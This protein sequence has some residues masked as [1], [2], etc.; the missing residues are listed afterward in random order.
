MTSMSM[1]VL[2]SGLPVSWARLSVA[3]TNGWVFMPTSASI[4][5]IL[6]ALWGISMLPMQLSVS[7]QSLACMPPNCRPKSVFMKDWKKTG[8]RG[9]QSRWC[10]WIWRMRLD[11][12]LKLAWQLGVLRIGHPQ[13]G[14]WDV[15]QCFLQGKVYW[16][17]FFFSWPMMLCRSWIVVSP[18]GRLEPS[19]AIDNFCA[20]P[21]LASQAKIYTELTEINHLK[22]SFKGGSKWIRASQSRFGWPLT[23]IEIRF[24]LC[25]HELYQAKDTIRNHQKEGIQR[26]NCPRNVDRSE[27]PW[28]NSKVGIS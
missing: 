3:R 18:V 26:S 4:G 8:N 7:L 20:D 25:E 19:S 21:E 24:G 11:F 14:A 1:F 5:I 2:L 12:W 17:C 28:M 23:T 16:R 27:L 9:L 13:L 6:D 10:L 22:K 15:M